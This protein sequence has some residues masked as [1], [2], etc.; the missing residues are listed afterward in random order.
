VTISPNFK[1]KIKKVRWC[2]RLNGTVQNLA[3]DQSSSVTS[4]KIIPFETSVISFSQKTKKLTLSSDH[5]FNWVIPCHLDKLM[6]PWVE[7]FIIDIFRGFCIQ[8]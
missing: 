4:L 8:F 2:V 1:I 6:S 7:N 3:L 5:G